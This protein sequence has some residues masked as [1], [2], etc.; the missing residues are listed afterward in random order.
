MSPIIEVIVVG[1]AVLTGVNTAL[2]IHLMRNRD[3]QIERLLSALLHTKG[4]TQA[5]RAVRPPAVQKA[6]EAKTASAPYTRNRQV[7]MSP[8]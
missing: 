2:I 5:A 1:G 7:G 3:S 6:E 4:E 8:R